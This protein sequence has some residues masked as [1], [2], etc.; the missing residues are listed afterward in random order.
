MRLTPLLFIFILVSACQTEEKEELVY[1]EYNFPNRVVKSQDSLSLKVLENLKPTSELSDYAIFQY[2]DIIADEYI[3][4]EKVNKT[5]GRNDEPIK[6]FS[7]KHEEAELN[8]IDYFDDR[9]YCSTIK[10]YGSS[11]QMTYWLCVKQVGEGTYFLSV[12][13]LQ[14]NQEAFNEKALMMIHSF[15]SN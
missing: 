12:S 3:Y 7:N 1:V 6:I 8:W 2:S 9:I 13:T 11:E 4:V 15:G 5:S 14:K 10:E